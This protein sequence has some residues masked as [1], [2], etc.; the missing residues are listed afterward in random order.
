M[1]EN[2]SILQTSYKTLNAT[3]CSFLQYT[4]ILRKQDFK[5]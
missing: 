5:S 2:N 4:L 3:G 1:L